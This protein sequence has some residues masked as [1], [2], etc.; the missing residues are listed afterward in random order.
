MELPFYAALNPRTAQIKIIVHTFYMWHDTAHSS[1]NKAIYIFF[2]SSSER[3]RVMI[4]INQPTRC[5]SFTSLLLDVYVWLNMFRVPLRQSSIAYN[6]ARSLWFYRWS[7]V[8]GTLF[9][10]VSTTNNAPT[11]TLQWWNQSLLAQL[12][13]PDDGRGGTRNMLSHT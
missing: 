6:C 13:A 4:Q 10:V 12:Y 11:S 2:N 8:V 3:W 9:V 7:V 1:E 5:N